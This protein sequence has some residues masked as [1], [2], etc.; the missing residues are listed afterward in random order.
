MSILEYLIFVFL[1]LNIIILY[2]PR[3]INRLSNKLFSKSPSKIAWLIIWVILATV[4][5]TLLNEVYFYLKGQINDSI[6]LTH[7]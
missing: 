6:I 7:V 1:I 2:L 5:F 4:Y 3:G